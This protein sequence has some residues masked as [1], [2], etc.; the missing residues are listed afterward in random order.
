MATIP[1]TVAKRAIFA[2]EFKSVIES[3]SIFSRV[4]TKLVASAKNIYSPFTSVGVAKA[5]TQ[6][7]RV[8]ISDLTIDKDELVLDR[9]IGNAITN[10]KEELDYANFDVTGMIRRD[11]YASVMKKVNSEAGTDFLADATSNTTAVTLNSS[12]TVASFLIGVAAEAEMA[13]VGLS[14]TVDGATVKRGD[15]HGKPFV[16][17]GTDAFIAIVSNIATLVAQS[18]LKGLDNGNMVETPYGVLVI[19]A[20]ASFSNSKQLLYGTG[21]AL[22]MAYREDQIEVDMGEMVSQTTYA[23]PSADLDLSANDPVLAKTWYIYAQTKGKNGIY[24]NVASLVT[25][26]LM[27]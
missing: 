20:G 13:S 18:S 25:K 9:Y 1:E 21:G 26:R 19:N 7:C 15:W 22:T 17:A 24:S 6:S 11:L 8:P 2:Q 23:G 4:S 12:A 16:V 27:S 14:Q 3:R 10:C 5:H